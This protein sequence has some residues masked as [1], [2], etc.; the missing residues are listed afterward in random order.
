MD[1]VRS[2]LLVKTI[3]FLYIM[4]NENS[5]RVVEPLYKYNE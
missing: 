2:L 3:Y 5:F 4:M 1:V